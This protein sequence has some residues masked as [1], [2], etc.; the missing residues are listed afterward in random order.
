[1]ASRD[2]WPALHQK[3]YDFL[4]LLTL[5]KTA[6]CSFM[7]DFATVEG[8]PTPF[9]PEMCIKAPKTSF[10]ALLNSLQS[11]RESS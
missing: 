3:D 7:A 10:S 9:A 2:E 4:L 5:E 11:C 6:F 8:D 1:L